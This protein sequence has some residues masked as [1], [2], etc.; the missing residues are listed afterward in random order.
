MICK[1]EGCTN[2]R[3]TRAKY[4]GN[5]CRKIV[6]QE[7]HKTEIAI[8]PQKPMKKQTVKALQ[9][10]AVAV[11]EIKPAKCGHIVPPGKRC[12]QKGCYGVLTKKGS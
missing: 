1:R 12:L 3:S 2:T 6:F 7:S 4:C 10:V 11:A 8:H 9:E 5:R